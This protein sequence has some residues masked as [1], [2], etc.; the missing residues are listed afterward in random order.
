[1]LQG[2]YNLSRLTDQVILPLEDAAFTFQLSGWCETVLVGFQKA[3]PRTPGILS[4]V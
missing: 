1:M 3:A 4:D 2:D